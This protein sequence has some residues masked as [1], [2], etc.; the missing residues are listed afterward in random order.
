MALAVILVVTGRRS[1]SPRH[2]SSR[3]TAIFYACSNFQSLQC[4]CCFSCSWFNVFIEISS[5]GVQIAVYQE[6]RS[7]RQGCGSALKDCLVLKSVL[8]IEYGWVRV[9][10]VLTVICKCRTEIHVHPFWIQSGDLWYKKGRFS[11]SFFS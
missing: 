2:C 6:T 10:L 5:L 8:G 7:A 4:K 1:T 3:V 9:D 11:I